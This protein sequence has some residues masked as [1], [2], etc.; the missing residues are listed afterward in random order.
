MDIFEAVCLTIWWT[1]GTK[2]RKNKRWGSFLYSTEVT[3]T[4]PEVIVTFLKYLRERMDVQNE[5][6]KVQLDARTIIF[7]RS[8]NALKMWLLKYPGAKVLA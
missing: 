8:K 5:R 6:I 4:D 3:N 1:E 2:I 7:L